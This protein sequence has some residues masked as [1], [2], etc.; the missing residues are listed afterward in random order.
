MG[1]PGI[2]LDRSLGETHEG[3]LPCPHRTNTIPELRKEPGG[4]LSSLR[5]RCQ[6]QVRGGGHRGA[7]YP[8]L[9]EVGGHVDRHQASDTEAGHGD[10]VVLEIVTYS[11]YFSELSK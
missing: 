2:C 1:R 4:R 7:K 8:S 6:L 9:H 5:N 10:S 11:R 3:E